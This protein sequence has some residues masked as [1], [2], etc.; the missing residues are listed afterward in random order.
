MQQIFIMNIEQMLRDFAA[1]RTFHKSNAII[2]MRIPDEVL[3]KVKE[4][5]AQQGV[6]YQS[7]ISSILFSL[8]GAKDATVA[9]PQHAVAPTAPNIPDQTN[10][11]S[12]FNP[13]MPPVVEFP[14][15]AAGPA[16]AA[17]ASKPAE[18][19]PANDTKI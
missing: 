2:N 15:T 14:S 13:A 19:E 18:P 1:F 8:V 11:V 9:A 12:H 4:I 3:D 6:P 7:L 17:P 10:S 16:P 5:A